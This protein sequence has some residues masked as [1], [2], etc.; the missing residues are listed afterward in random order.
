MKEKVGWMNERRLLPQRFS[1]VSCAAVVALLVLLLPSFVGALPL[2]GAQGSSSTPAS[3]PSNSVF[4]MMATAGTPNS[5]NLL[6][7]ASEGSFAVAYLAYGSGVSP[8]MSTAGIPDPSSTIV[9]STSHNANY[10][11]WFFTVK[12][13]LKSSDG[14]NVTAQD[15]VA[16]YSS[17]FA[18]NPQYDLAGIHGEVTT[19]TAVNSSTAEFVLNQS[20]AHLPEKINGMVD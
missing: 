12:P 14:T 6:D 1:K 17:N 15:I 19:V 2:A 5:F 8:F 10:T 13:G 11:S 20:D 3:C 9:G 18:L 4:T 7:A 16:T